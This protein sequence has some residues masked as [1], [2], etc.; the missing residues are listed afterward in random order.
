MI[1]IAIGADHRGFAL[2]SYLMA[3]QELKKFNIAWHDVGCSDAI[4]RYDYPVYAIAACKAMS[5][6][7]ASL[8][9]LI[10]GSGVGM[11]VTANRFNGIYAGLVWNTAIAQ[12]LS[13][14][15]TPR[16]CRMLNAPLAGCS[17]R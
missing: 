4:E 17:G 11:A 10:C 5:A 15:G 8:G 9:I 13:D 2:K 7:Q 3:C 14:A 12:L 16:A 6:G 1:T